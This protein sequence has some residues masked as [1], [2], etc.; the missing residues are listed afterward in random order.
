M[1]PLFLR[2]VKEHFIPI[3]TC[4]VRE[5]RLF[6]QEYIS[7]KGKKCYYRFW[8]SLNSVIKVNWSHKFQVSRVSF[9]MGFSLMNIANG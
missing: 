8:G 4:K 3:W 7:K 6:N 1:L 9:P 2:M 5:G